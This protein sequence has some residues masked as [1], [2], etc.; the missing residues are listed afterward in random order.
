MTTGRAP[1]ALLL[2]GTLAACA[3]GP[4][5]VRPA[6]AV[7]AQ[8]KESP[9][10][11]PAQ[12]ADREAR[13]PWW[14]MFDDAELDA[15]QEQAAVANLD[16]AVAE[17][18]YRQALAAEDA[19]RSAYFPLVTAS[20][21]VTRSANAVAGLRSTAS[22]LRQASVGASWVPDL[23][24]GVRRS[25]EQ[26]SASTESNAADLGAAALSLQ[27]TLAVDYFALRVADEQQ[28]L[29]EEAVR[30]YQKSLDLTISRYKGG[31]AAQSDVA[32]ARAQLEATRA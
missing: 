24:G 5:Y 22:T 26:A 11:K 10:W 9:D 2:C 1:L 25:V 30:A 31:V 14:R 13:G 17:A 20:A 29:L 19:A 4:D 18:H 12:P 6:V 15:L 32:L 27:S 23:W 7:P 21:G 16:V 28:H 8:F 3:V